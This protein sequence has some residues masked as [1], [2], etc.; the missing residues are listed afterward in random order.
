MQAYAYALLAKGEGRDNTN[1]V[2]GRL[3]SCLSFYHCTHICGKKNQATAPPQ[4]EISSELVMT[5]DE[6]G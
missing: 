2:F 6:N 4:I 3:W 5:E 1:K